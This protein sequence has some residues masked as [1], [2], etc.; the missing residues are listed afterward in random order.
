MDLL[1]PVCAIEGEIAGWGRAENW[2]YFPSINKG[3]WKTGNIRG[4]GGLR[5]EFLPVGFWGFWAFGRWAKKGRFLR[6]GSEGM[7]KVWVGV[8][9]IGGVELRVAVS[10]R[11][12]EKS[13]SGSSL[14]RPLFAG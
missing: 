1:L 11:K 3:G 4:F 12:H 2:E 7:A 14:R 13:L 6:S 5:E 8:R 9:L 10:V